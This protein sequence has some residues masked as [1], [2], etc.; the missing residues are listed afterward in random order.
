MKIQIEIPQKPLGKIRAGVRPGRVEIDSKTK[1]DLNRR[2]KH[3]KKWWDQ[4]P[5]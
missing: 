2:P 4:E 5:V 1:Q 3:Q